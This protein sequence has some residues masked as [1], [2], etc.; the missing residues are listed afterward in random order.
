V[1]GPQSQSGRGGEEKNFQPLPELE[2]PIIHYVVQRY[3]TQLPQL[4][5]YKICFNIILQSMPSPPS[6]LSTYSFSL[7]IFHHP[8]AI[9][10]GTS[11]S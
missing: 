10:N 8:N 5:F 4:H 11:L 7:S 1:G 6:R 9:H 2:P 3:I